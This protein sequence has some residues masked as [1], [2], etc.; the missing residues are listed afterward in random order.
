MVADPRR[1]DLAHE[2]LEASEIGRVRRLRPTDAE[3]YRMLDQR[4]V[5]QHALQVVKRLAAFDHEIFTDDFEE[6]DRRALTQDVPIVR[7]AQSHAD[8]EI[9]NTEPGLGHARH[10]PKL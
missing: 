4:V 3:R 2:L 8:A 1:P 6:I 5:L 7:H 10:Y 9:R